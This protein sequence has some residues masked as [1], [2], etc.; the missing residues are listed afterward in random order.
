MYASVL[1]FCMEDAATAMMRTTNRQ[2]VPQ[3]D[4]CREQGNRFIFNGFRATSTYST[5]SY[6]RSTRTC[7]KHHHKLHKCTEEF[8]CPLPTNLAE[9]TLKELDKGPSISDS[10]EGQVIY[11]RSVKRHAL[12]WTMLLPS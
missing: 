5:H 7:T 4:R 3:E 1:I 9:A 10:P 8:S 2:D 12:G 11:Q 6:R